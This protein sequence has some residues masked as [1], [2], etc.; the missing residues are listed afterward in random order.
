MTSTKINTGADDISVKVPTQAAPKRMPTYLPPEDHIL[1]ALVQ[2]AQSNAADAQEARRTLE[3]AQA[4]LVAATTDEERADAELALVEAD[5]EARFFQRAANSYAKAL[6]LWRAGVRPEQTSG[7]AWV[8]PSSRKGEP[9]HILTRVAGELGCCC[10]AG[11]S[12]HWAKALLVAI[13]LAEEMAELDVEAEPE[14]AEPDEWELTLGD[15]PLRIYEADCE[16]I[17]GVWLVV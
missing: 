4:A 10:S 3:Q 14:P 12:W 1:G 5:A 16:N 8:L 9:D 7:G 13:E 15:L 2:L 17:D 6:K 11:K